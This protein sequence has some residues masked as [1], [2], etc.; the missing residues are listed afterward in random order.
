MGPDNPP[1]PSSDCG[2]HPYNA[3]AH[4]VNVT[5][6]ANGNV[7]AGTLTF[8]SGDPC[9]GVA[10]QP[11]PNTTISVTNGSGPRA[12]PTQAVT[13]ASATDV[14]NWTSQVTTVEAQ[15]SSQMQTELVAHAAGKPIAK[16]P[17]GNGEAIAFVVTPQ[18]F[19]PAVGAQ[20][21]AAADHGERHG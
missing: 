18:P 12:G 16:D 3:T 4:Y 14:A 15:L 20:F 2:T 11:T 1:P 10:C 7:D 8:W 19:P 17:A 6:G 21:A 13:A 9:P 5:A